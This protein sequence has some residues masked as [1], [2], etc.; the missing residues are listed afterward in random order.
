M[1]IQTD[2]FL[3]IK[4]AKIKSLVTGNKGKGQARQ[5]WPTVGGRGRATEEGRAASPPARRLHL[6][7]IYLTPPPDSVPPESIIQS[8]LCSQLQ[9]IGNNQNAYEFSTIL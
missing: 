8:Q 1:Q 9:T 2:Q 4:S 6:T 5:V 3:H 7:F